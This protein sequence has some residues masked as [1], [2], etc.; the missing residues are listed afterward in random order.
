M[1]KYE[2]RA[3][4]ELRN[5]TLKSNDNTEKLTLLSWKNVTRKKIYYS[6]QED[7][8]VMRKRSEM[9]QAT[10]RELRERSKYTHRAKLLEMKR[11]MK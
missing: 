4:K 11:E 3:I 5:Q 6:K 9:E 8:I 10:E 1:E 7:R 2:Q